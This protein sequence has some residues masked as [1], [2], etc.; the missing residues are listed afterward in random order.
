MKNKI[1]FVSET[2]IKAAT[3]INLN[4]ETQLI[5]AAI[6]DAQEL[7]VQEILGS[8]LY[9]AVQNKIVDGSISATTNSSYKELL[10]DHIIPSTIHWTVA[11][12]L[13]YINFKMMNKSVGQQAS[14]NTTPVDLD[15][16]KYLQSQST[17][18]AE[19]VTQRMADYLVANYNNFPEYHNQVNIDDLLPKTN[20]YFCGMAL[21][22][23]KDF[24]E[25][26]RGKTGN[27]A[28]GW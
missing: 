28:I 20:A 2:D 18:K 5:N 14:D 15:T 25:D 24:S 13:P 1:Y 23:A 7:H 9:K 19:F 16:I 11:E 10:D 4:V 27:N 26:L 3:V 17:S 6:L 8:K 12:A 22:D 21:D